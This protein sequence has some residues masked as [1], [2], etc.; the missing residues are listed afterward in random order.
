M[1]IDPDCLTAP[2]ASVNILFWHTINIALLYQVNNYCP[3][4]KH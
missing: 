3:Y 4:Q 1:C 2:V